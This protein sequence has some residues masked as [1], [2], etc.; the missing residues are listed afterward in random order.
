MGR[1][2]KPWP[3]KMKLDKSMV[4]AMGGLDSPLYT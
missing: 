2:P 3:P 4:E 1:D